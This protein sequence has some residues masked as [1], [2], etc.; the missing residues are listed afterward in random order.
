MLRVV[1]IAIALQYDLQPV[2][3]AQIRLYDVNLIYCYE[4]IYSQINNP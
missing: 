4:Y 2:C 1:W 3:G